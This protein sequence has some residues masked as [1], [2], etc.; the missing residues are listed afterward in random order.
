MQEAILTDI[1][2]ELIEIKLLLAKRYRNEISD[3]YRDATN[4]RIK[5]TETINRVQTQ[6]LK[7]M[8]GGF[9]ADH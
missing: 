4:R 5:A 1:L 6:A 7:D 9:D 3:A 8:I 2:G